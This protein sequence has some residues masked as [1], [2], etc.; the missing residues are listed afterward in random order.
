M[1]T[2]A[3]G[4]LEQVRA[5][6]ASGRLLA[7][8]GTRA[9]ASSA[10]TLFDAGTRKVTR[11]LAIPTHT[12]ALAFFGKQLVVGGIDGQLHRFDFTSGESAGA[13]LA[14]QGGVTALSATVTLLASTGVDGK[15]IV[16]A[17]GAKKY[18]FIAPG[19]QRAVALD[20]ANGRVAA[21]GDDG[22]VRIFTFGQKQP[23]EMPHLLAAHLALRIASRAYVF[24]SGEMNVDRRYPCA[25]CSSMKSNPARSDILVALA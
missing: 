13:A 15:V 12:A 17:D 20:P 9:E 16:W 3:I 14:H 21:A 22:I 25:K 1:A 19:P 18:E 8:G 11:T 7:I 5:L 23:R 6:A 4:H 10:V 24:E 2:Y